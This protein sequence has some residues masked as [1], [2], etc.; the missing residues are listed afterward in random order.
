MPQE[1]LE[2]NPWEKGTKTWVKEWVKDNVGRRGY[3]VILWGRWKQCEEEEEGDEATRR[4]TGGECPKGRNP[5][6]SRKQMRRLGE[7]QRKACRIA[8]QQSEDDGNSKAGK[9]TSWPPPEV[10]EPPMGE[11]ERPG[12]H[13][14][15]KRRAARLRKEENMTKREQTAKV[16]KEKATI[17]AKK[18][19]EQEDILRKKGERLTRNQPKIVEWFSKEELGSRNAHAG[20]KTGVG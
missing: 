5:P 7:P 13:N 20:G 18:K 2:G 15:K 12:V 4:Q 3:D 14:D 9:P 6:T 19:K 16:R 17:R 8:E 11:P 10:G 1:M